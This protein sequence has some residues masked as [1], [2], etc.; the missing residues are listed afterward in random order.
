MAPTM[1]MRTENNQPLPSSGQ[2][3]FAYHTPDHSALEAEMQAAGGTA[4]PGAQ[5]PEAFTV[6][7]WRL[8]TSPH[9]TTTSADVLECRK[10]GLPSLCSQAPMTSANPASGWPYHSAAWGVLV[11]VENQGMTLIRLQSPPDSVLSLPPNA[12]IT[13]SGA[14]ETYAN[15][16]LLGSPSISQH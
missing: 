11:F 10:N 16:Q 13:H 12:A 9:P 15:T 6:W 8:E 2:A 14:L 1:E 7:D 5:S 3:M 4:G